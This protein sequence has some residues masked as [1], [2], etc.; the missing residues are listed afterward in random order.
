MAERNI[1]PLSD[2]VSL[3]ENKR[4]LWTFM[5]LPYPYAPD[6]FWFNST[7][8]CGTV[9]VDRLIHALF[10]EHSK[11]SVRFIREHTQGSWRAAVSTLPCEIWMSHACEGC[12]APRLCLCMSRKN[13]VTWKTAGVVKQRGSSRKDLYC[14]PDCNVLKALSR[15]LHSA[16]IVCSHENQQITLPWPFW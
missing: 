1:K 13:Y 3:F 14:V 15:L 6:D 16:K 12:A 5:G 8:E 9:C 7:P 2:M 4:R 11:L 10:R